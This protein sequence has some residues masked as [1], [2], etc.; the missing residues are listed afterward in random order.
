[1]CLIVTEQC[2]VH[3]NIIVRDKFADCTI[4]ALM[5][6]RFYK[7]TRLT[8]LVSKARLFSR[9][10]LKVNT[11]PTRREICLKKEK[12]NQ[13]ER[14][15]SKMLVKVVGF[16]FQSSPEFSK[17]SLIVL[18]TC[19]QFWRRLIKK[20]F[21][22]EIAIQLENYVLRVRR[23]YGNKT[24]CVESQQRSIGNKQRR[25]NFSMYT[26]GKVNSVSWKV[27]RV[28][29]SCRVERTLARQA[30][31]KGSFCREN[32]HAATT[33]RYANNIIFLTFLS[34]VFP[35]RRHR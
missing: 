30:T 29:K 2:D 21:L 16:S 8:K 23:P 11:L 3:E 31:K 18:T 24:D 26:A 33:R 17:I 9:N 6:P 25:C 20:F 28:Y 15:M 14:C 35:P 4:M 19:N 27:S 10:L 34:R 12:K 32:F 1:M 7:L 13:T 5:H 22:G